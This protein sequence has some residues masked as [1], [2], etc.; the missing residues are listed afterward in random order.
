MPQT[1]AATPPVKQP[2]P[3]IAIY[4]AGPITAGNQFNNVHNAIVAAKTLRDAGYCVMVPHRSALDEIAFGG[5]DYEMWMRE[6]FEL[7]RRADALCRLP[8]TSSGS[9]REVAFAKSLKKPVYFGVDECVK[10]K[11]S[12]L[13]MMGSMLD[14]HLLV[15]E[16]TEDANAAEA[17]TEEIHAQLDKLKARSAVAFRV[18]NDLG[19]PERE[20][21]LL[22][23]HADPIEMLRKQGYKLGRVL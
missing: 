4:L 1:E 11:E 5:Q 7:V 17:R 13:K 22:V 19:I 2:D 20:L 23:N 9:D 10:E 8:G 14:E 18:L 12:L 3:M 16:L 6:D 15:K 21:D